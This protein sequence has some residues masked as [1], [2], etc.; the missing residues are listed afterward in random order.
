[1]DQRE[2]RLRGGDE[3]TRW[4]ENVIRNEGFNR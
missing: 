4:V 2:E 1:M 3:R